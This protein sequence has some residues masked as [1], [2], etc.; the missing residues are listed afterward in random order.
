MY[1]IPEQVKENAARRWALPDRVFFAC[2]A[3]HVL[4]HAFLA[5]HRDEGWSAVWIKPAKGFI[6]NHIVVRRD[7]DLAFDYHGYARWTRLFAHA[8]TKANR[9]W[10]GWSAEAVAIPA[11]VLVD[12]AESREFGRLHGG[13][14]WLGAPQDFL[15]DALPR[16]RAFVARH[17]PPMALDTID[18]VMA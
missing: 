18:H 7:D 2:G 10:P 15:H 1:V 16:A 8:H 4:A 12:E 6:G 13:R 17:G 9:W 11:H 3:C 5:A 14:L